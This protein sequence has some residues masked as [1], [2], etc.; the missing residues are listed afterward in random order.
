MNLTIEEENFVKISYIVLEIVPKYIRQLF[1]DSWNAKFPGNIWDNTKKSGR[2]LWNKVTAKVPFKEIETILRNGD[3][4]KWDVT[5]LCFVLLKSN[6]GLLVPCRPKNKRTQPLTESELVDQL[7]EIR[8]EYFG[9][10]SS[11]SMPVST[12][13]NALA[14]IKAIFLDPKL[15]WHTGVASIANIEAS[16]IK[17]RLSEDL[18]SQL[19]AE[20]KLNERYKE[21]LG[22]LEWRIEKNSLEL[23]RHSETLASQSNS[24]E[25]LGGSFEQHDSQLK[26]LHEDIQ[27]VKFLRYE[28]TRQGEER[29]SG[30]KKVRIM[31]EYE[32]EE[33]EVSKNNEEISKLRSKYKEEFS[34][35]YLLVDIRSSMPESYR[36]CMLFDIWQG[37]FGTGSGRLAIPVKVEAQDIFNNESQL[38]L[39]Y[40]DA[41]CGKTTFLEQLTLS[42]V[43]KTTIF[44][45]EARHFEL[46]LFLK[47]RTLNNY[48]GC[49]NISFESVVGMELGIE[50]LKE[51]KIEGKHVLVILDGLQEYSD[52]KAV[53]SGQP[54]CPMTQI[55]RNLVAMNSTILKGH[56]TFIS[57]NFNAGVKGK[58]RNCTE[59]DV[60]GFDS[61]PVIEQFI[62][63]FANGN[64]ELH[65]RIY[66][67]IKSCAVLKDLCKNPSIL[68]SLCSMIKLEDE[69]LK[70]EEISKQIDVYIWVFIALLKQHTQETDL[71]GVNIHRLLEDGRVRRFVDFLCKI[72]YQLLVLETNCCKEDLINGLRAED[73]VFMNLFEA[74]AVKY[75][76]I[77]LFSFSVVQEC[78]A[79]YH[80]VNVEL[81]KEHFLMTGEISP[82]GIIKFLGGYFGNVFLRRNIIT[83]LFPAVEHVSV[84][85]ISTVA[86]I[87][88][89]K[90]YHPLTDSAW[91]NFV[92]EC[93][94]DESAAQAVFSELSIYPARNFIPR[95]ALHLEML[96]HFVKLTFPVMRLRHQLSSSLDEFVFNFG[97]IKASN[98][99]LTPIQFLG[100]IRIFH[101]LDNVAL[102]SCKMSCKLDAAQMAEARSLL[103]EMKRPIPLHIS[104]FKDIQAYERNLLNAAGVVMTHCYLNFFEVT[105]AEDFVYSIL[106]NITESEKMKTYDFHFKNCDIE[107]NALAQ[108]LNRL[109]VKDSK[110]RVIDPTGTSVDFQCCTGLISSHLA[111]A[112]LKF[113]GI[114]FYKLNISAEFVAALADYLSERER[115]GV[116]GMPKSFRMRDCGLGG[117]NLMPHLLKIC[118]SIADTDFGATKYNAEDAGALVHHVQKH[119][120]LKEVKDCRC[121]IRFG[122]EVENF[123]RRKLRDISLP[124]A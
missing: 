6:I 85:Q 26:S 19:N 3:S 100:L 54:A 42:W 60:C 62:L 110:P 83:V 116:V 94:I 103:S 29:F 75:D 18:Q 104:H 79:A 44:G 66:S 27:E 56:T 9:H 23:E 50:R 57:V 81:K 20:Y 11:F 22:E 99:C 39:L 93:I 32:V 71:R 82:F 121:Y 101:M 109:L 4:T 76:D 92:F 98:I 40:G 65:Q 80:W 112:I 24:L 34:E 41:G 61:L 33:P 28:H 15:N 12:F 38:Y 90:R 47:C 1:V 69:E 108:L 91:I 68:A 43:H 21:Y 123:I 120:V 115:S 87:L 5:A 10:R 107:C 45:N 14:D 88:L 46:L 78:L 124:N 53:F 55:L 37:S 114:L 48:L 70:I 72:A 67:K 25:K 52:Y 2:I 97:I 86:E 118:H 63:E 95:S 35:R 7:R 89:P 111:A 96:I 31:E 77:Y 51:L 105:I 36:E 30:A 58:F 74:F 117:K 119:I 49:S 106:E 102:R 17:T 122:L 84:K 8:N 13:A 16:P 73:H 113:D 64:E 59:F